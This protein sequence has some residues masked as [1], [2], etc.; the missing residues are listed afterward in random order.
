[1]NKKLSNI[2]DEA[3]ASEIDDLV[4]RNDVPDVPADTLN[5]I[6]SKVYARTGIANIK[7]KR[8]FALKLRPYIAAAVCFALILGVIIITPMPG[9]NVPVEESTSI[10]TSHTPI[11]IDTTVSPEKLSGNCYEYVAGTSSSGSGGSNSPPE[12]PDFNF[13]ISYFIVKAKVVK[14]HPGLYYG[15]D[16]NYAYRLIQMECLQVIRGKDM[17]QYF[18]Y[19]IPSYLFVDM[20]VYDS[21]LI[22]MSQIGTENYVLKNGTENQAE[23]LPL[24]VFAD[25]NGQP[26]HPELGNIIAFSDGVFDESLWQ[27]KSWLYGYQFA[28]L[29]LDDPQNSRLVVGRGDSE[30]DVISVINDRIEEN[31][32]WLE[33]R[34]LD[35]TLLT[36]RFTSQAAK[37]ALEYVKPFA[38]GVF[39]Q[40]LNAQ[41]I[42]YRRFIN[43]CQTEETVTIDLL[44]E[45]V[46]Y[47][48]VRYTNED[49]ANIENIA[50]HLSEKAKE[51]AEQMP[52]PPHTDPKGKKLLNLYLRA[53]YAKVDGKVYGVVK[54]VWDHMEEGDYYIKYC[55]EDYIL[56]DM[57]AS[58]AANISREDL[59][60]LLG[61]RNV[62]KEPFGTAIEMPMY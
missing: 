40:Y 42:I 24:H 62:S 11:I 51:Y 18:Y 28:K 26:G 31:K 3:K 21:L 60:A 45:E 47:S 7:K 41:Y 55:D 59:I 15:L 9:R 34:Y 33:G 52:T 14:N 5:S 17:P 53:W 48:E 27:N 13:D 29:Y 49:L 22:S 61:P 43:G 32:Q 12:P 58:T 4:G 46:I 57:S 37:D 38:N 20:S 36:L 19:L 50:A 23:A 25:L 54:T 2:F 8:V 39:S 35:P 10:D 6:K 56:Y 44:T 30:S 16:N 1:M